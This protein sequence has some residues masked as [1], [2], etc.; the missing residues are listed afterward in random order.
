MCPRHYDGALSTAQIS[1]RQTAAVRDDQMRSKEK[2]Q[3][4]ETSSS[5][6]SGVPMQQQ[7]K[8]K[9]GY[10]KR[11]LLP[12]AVIALNEAKV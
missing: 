9:K 12:Q 5:Q 8:K 6:V 7:L 2:S 3:F 11:M 4:K 10:V 1:R